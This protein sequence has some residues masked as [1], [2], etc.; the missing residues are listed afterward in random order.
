[1][2][3][4][5]PLPELYIRDIAAIRV[6]AD[7]RRLEILQLMQEPT[8][9]K[10]VAGALDV[11]PASLYYHVNLLAEH[12]LIR[13]VGHSIETGIVEKHYQVTAREFK[14]TNPLLTGGAVP[15]DAADAIYTN[16]LDETKRDFRLAFQRRSPDE[17]SPP[18]TPFF[19]KKRLRLSDEQL[20]AFHARLDGLMQEAA[21]LAAQNG[22]SGEK[23]YELTV[24]FYDKADEKE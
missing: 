11:A 16:L 2:D 24:V 5:Q 3:K 9:V 8:T 15:D 22:V 10:A 14:L 20:T 19:S 21:T 6:L 7:P 13:V 12:N 17:P 18:R 4:D 1:M 23:L